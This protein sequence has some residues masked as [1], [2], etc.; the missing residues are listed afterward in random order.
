M[1]IIAMITSFYN[2]NLKDET[3]VKRKTFSFITTNTILCR[4]E[5][6]KLK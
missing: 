1:M 2:K 4:R 5:K 3:I 6:V